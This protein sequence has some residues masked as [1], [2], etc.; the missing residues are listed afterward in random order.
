[1]LMILAFLGLIMLTGVMLI[2]KHVL[3]EVPSYNSVGFIATALWSNDSYLRIL[4]VANKVISKINEFIRI[5]LQ[6][7]TPK[8]SLQIT[9]KLSIMQT[10]LA[11]WTGPHN[12]PACYQH[13]SFAIPPY[14]WRSPSPGTSRS[15]SK[16]H[17]I[18]F[19]MVKNI[20]KIG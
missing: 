14:Y 13:P 18:A 15:L 20:K 11:T 19:Y 6:L 7:S 4:W 16:K 10:T 3:N 1:M 8:K 5:F 2:K 17:Q 9:R 12:P